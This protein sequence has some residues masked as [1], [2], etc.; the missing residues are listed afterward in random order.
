MS[1]NEYCKLIP[2]FALY[3]AKAKL[4]TAVFYLISKQN[5]ED[6]L[7]IIACSIF[8]GG[9]EAQISNRMQKELY[10]FATRTLDYQKK[11]NR[12]A[13]IDRSKYYLAKKIQHCDICG[14][15]T[16]QAMYKSFFPGK[17]CCRICRNRIIRQD[18]KR[19][20]V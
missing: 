9:S 3:Y 2:N 7:Q 17:N 16:F 6:M 13:E 15:D 5:K 8:E 4:N 19:N 10:Y 14:K 1:L 12:I 11:E 18:K 20:K